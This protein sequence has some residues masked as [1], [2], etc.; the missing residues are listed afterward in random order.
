MD[1]TGQLIGGFLAIAGLMV[2]TYADRVARKR[3]NYPMYRLILYAISIMFVAIGM[4]L[5][6][7]GG[8]LSL[9]IPSK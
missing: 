1:S 7:D 5:F 4:N 3:K 9:I 6:S 8:L 2:I